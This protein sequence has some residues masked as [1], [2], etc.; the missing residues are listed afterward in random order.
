MQQ[1]LIKLHHRQIFILMLTC[2]KI[3]SIITKKDNIVPAT[4]VASWDVSEA[5]DGSVM[6]YVE[7]D[8]TGNS[9]YKVTIGGKRW[10]YCK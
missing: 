10:N 5:Q 6:A 1:R 2:Q 9:T 8:G 4:A 7:D 3:T